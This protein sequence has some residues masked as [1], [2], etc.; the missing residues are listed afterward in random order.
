MAAPPDFNDEAAKVARSMGCADAEVLEKA[1]AQA[2]QM[3]DENK[4]G[5]REL[6]R[7]ADSM[8]APLVNTL[9]RGMVKASGVRGAAKSEAHEHI[10]STMLKGL[11]HGAM[12]LDYVNI[13]TRKPETAYLTLDRCDR[14]HDILAQQAKIKSRITPARWKEVERVM[15]QLIF[16][17]RQVYRRVALEN[18]DFVRTLMQKVEGL[19]DWT[20]GMNTQ[21]D[22]GNCTLYIHADWPDRVGLFVRF[23]EPPAPK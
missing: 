12:R 6:M 21:A 17:G 19:P 20:V 9:F 14:N 10:K 4:E 8:G 11:A 16:M 13:E 2:R 7:L 23:D 22:A 1:K 15:S 5:L 3:L 18:E